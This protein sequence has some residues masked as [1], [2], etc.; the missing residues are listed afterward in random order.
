MIRIYLCPRGSIARSVGSS[1]RPQVII[2]GGAAACH[3]LALHP[4][5]WLRSST[6]SHLPYSCAPPARGTARP[7]PTVVGTSRMNGFTMVGPDR[8]AHGRWPSQ[9]P[10]R[11]AT[12]RLHITTAAL[13]TVGFGKS[14]TFGIQRCLMIVR[15]TVHATQN[16]LWPS[17]MADP[18]G[19]LGRHTRVART[20]S[21]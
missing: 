19:A 14:T 9:S 10:S 18:I 7:T 21:T 15:T 13:S 8:R 20:S 6:I 5:A 3:T 16:R 4:S 1:D 12:A 17:Q 11:V 2:I